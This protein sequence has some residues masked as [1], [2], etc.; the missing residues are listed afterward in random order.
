[1]YEEIFLGA[2]SWSNNFIMGLSMANVLLFQ[3]TQ[4]KHFSWSFYLLSIR[5]QNDQFRE[6]F[7]WIF[8]I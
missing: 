7:F 8:K 6:D 3:N 5:K 4:K 1:M 2:F